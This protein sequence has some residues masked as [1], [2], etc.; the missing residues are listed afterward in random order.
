MTYSA[1]TIEDDDEEEEEICCRGQIIQW[2]EDDFSDIDDNG[3]RTNRDEGK[4]DVCG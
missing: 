2:D 3:R 4:D 1:T